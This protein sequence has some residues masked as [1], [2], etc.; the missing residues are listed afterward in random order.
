MYVISAMVKHSFEKVPKE[1]FAGRDIGSGYSTGY[2]C[3]CD[4]KDNSIMYFS[5]LEYS[6]K[7]FHEEEFWLCHHPSAEVGSVR[8][9]RTDYTPVEELTISQQPN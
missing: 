3:W 8:I 7:W 6:K 1:R 5:T 4:K 2:P 9:L